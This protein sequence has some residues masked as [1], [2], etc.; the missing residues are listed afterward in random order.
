VYFY[1]TIL[2]RLSLF[3]YSYLLTRLLSFLI[4]SFF[5][6]EDF[7]ITLFYYIDI[8]YRVPLSYD[9]IL[10]ATKIATVLSN[11]NALK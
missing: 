9:D 7:F 4:S 8:R 10:R 2:W 1:L 11:V 3:I 6:N 5:V